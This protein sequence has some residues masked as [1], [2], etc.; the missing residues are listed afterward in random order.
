MNFLFVDRI[1]EF[2]PSRSARGL[3]CVSLKDP[4]LKINSEGLSVLSSCV[5]GEALG[6]LTAWIV[7]HA[8]DFSKRPVAGIADEVSIYREVYAGEILNLNTE[9]ETLDDKVVLYN[10]FATV[11]EELVFC[12]KRAMGPL[13]PME[14]FIDP[15]RARE[16]FKMIYREGQTHSTTA[17]NKSNSFYPTCIPNN[18]SQFSFFDSIL[19]LTPEGLTAQK[20]ISLLAPYF[21]DHFPRKPVLPLTLL[22]EGNLEL[23]HFFLQENFKK[24]ANLFRPKSLH[25]IRIRQFIFPGD[26]IVTTVHLKEKL[27]EGFLFSIKTQLEGKTVCSLEAVFEVV[28]TLVQS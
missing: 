4:Y 6:Q 3:K 11:G 22:L 15:Q 27:E 10:S 12:L 5:I 7:M 24:E 28:S 18:E 19:D 20:H 17:C 21:D 14:D 8:N 9:I 23:I 13:L 2:T 26:S 25:K 16:Q 1:I